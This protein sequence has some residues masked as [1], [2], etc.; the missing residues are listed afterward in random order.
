MDNLDESGADNLDR[1]HAGC[2]ECGWWKKWKKL[3]TLKYKI[4]LD[5][6]FIPASLL[7]ITLEVN[8]WAE[9]IYAERLSLI[10]YSPTVATIL[11]I[12]ILAN[13]EFFTCSSTKNTF[14]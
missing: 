6:S 2:C 11:L 7:K 1:S 4:L 10:D 8:I 5:L 3:L 9:Y 13:G 14:L 12:L